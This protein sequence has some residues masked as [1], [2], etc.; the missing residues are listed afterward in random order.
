MTHDGRTDAQQRLHHLLDPVPP[1]DVDG[2]GYID[3]LGEAPQAG[4]STGFA[5]RLMRN[6]V[7]SSVYERWW[8]PALGRIAKGRHGPSMSEEHS[9][10]ADLLDLRPGHVVLDVACGTGAFTRGFARKVGPEGLSIGLDASRTMLARAVAET[11]PNEPV[12]YLRAD[13]VRPPLRAGSLDAVCCFAALHLFDDAETALTSFAT[14]L[15]PGGRLAVLTS[16][17][18]GMQP[19][20]TLDSTIGTVSGMRMFDHGEVAA[21]LEQRGFT[22]VSEQ[23]SGVVQIVGARRA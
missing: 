5:Q 4:P 7:V 21:L 9:I 8:R 2:P 22:D 19:L 15:K 12:A 23:V 6:E 13:A 14:L 10:A 1:A 20:R 18:R 17:R 11:E 3:L 16:A